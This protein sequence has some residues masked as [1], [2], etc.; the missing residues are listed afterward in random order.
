MID[1]ATFSWPNGAACAVS[2]TYDDALPCHHE[3]VAP[4]LEAVGLRGTFNVVLSSP[5]FLDHVSSWKDVAAR[6]HEI[7][8]HTLFHPCRS[9]QPIKKSRPEAGYNLCDY[10]E[11][12]FRDEVM[13]ANWILTQTD[14]RRERTFANTCHNTTIGRGAGERSIEPILADYF[15]A[16]RGGC[17][18]RMVDIA[19]V[20]RMNLGTT[21][22]D[23]RGFK[24][25]RG[26]VEAALRAGGWMIYTIH[27][28][29]EGTHKL[30]IDSGEHLRLV[31]WLGAHGTKIWTAPMIEVA[32]HLRRHE[33]G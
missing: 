7:G 2:L 21:G 14:G 19:R 23:E 6:G 15:V 17:T 27:G 30:F 33:N 22:A 5:G 28:V 9:Q 31:E 12:R 24:S 11:K 26:E 13:L 16:A 3:A 20:N 10:T 4:I 8:N 32:G 18:N 1:C 29:G 25:L